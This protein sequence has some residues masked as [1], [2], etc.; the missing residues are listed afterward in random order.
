MWKVGSS[1]NLK[2]LCSRSPVRVEF[3]NFRQIYFFGLN[4][5][6]S[7]SVGF[8]QSFF[9]SHGSN[10]EIIISV[11]H[12][13]GVRK[14]GSYYSDGLLVKSQVKTANPSSGSQLLFSFDVIVLT[15]DCIGL[16]NCDVHFLLISDILYTKPSEAAGFTGLALLAGFGFNAAFRVTVKRM[17]WI[18]LFLLQHNSYHSIDLSADQHRCWMRHLFSG[19]VSALNLWNGP[20][21][22][23]VLICSPAGAGLFQVCLHKSEPGWFSLTLCRPSL[24]FRHHWLI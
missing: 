2:F 8:M 6:Y 10:V 9:C 20:Q 22:P 15:Y 18:N 21:C 16:I 5:I 17:K 19:S 3:R 12:W 24:S 7:V 4:I 14:I 11:N 13:H 23:T 1:F